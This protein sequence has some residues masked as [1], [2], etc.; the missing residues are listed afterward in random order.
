MFLG[1]V[2]M[3]SCACIK[4]G[5]YD[6][7]MNKNSFGGLLQF[8]SKE[9]QLVETVNE[10]GEDKKYYYYQSTVEKVKRVLDVIGYSIKST[11]ECFNEYFNYLT[12]E[13]GYEFTNFTLEE[14]HSSFTFDLWTEAV[15]KYARLLSINGYDYYDTAEKEKKECISIAESFVLDSLA[16]MDNSYFGVDYDYANPF[17]IFRVV[18]D[19]FDDTT[20][21]VLDY[22]DLYLGGWCEETPSNEEFEVSKT[23]I[24]TEGK[25]DVEVISGAMKLLYP[26]LCKCFSFMNFTEY[27]VNGST[28]FLTHYIKAFIA[29]GVQNQVIAI[30]DNDSAGKAELINL[31]SLQ[32]PSRFKILTLPDIEIANNYP[33]LGPSGNEVMNI[34]GL[35]CSIEF[36]LGAELL[37]DNDEFIPIQW[38]GYVEKTKTYQGEIMKKGEIQ[39]RFKKKLS[40]C[41][42]SKRYTKE[43][44]KEMNQLL[45]SIFSAFEN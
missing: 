15:K 18:L 17:S 10:D 36:F 8:F 24:L 43:N 44:W 9:D 13:D 31:S 25:F 45:I 6:F 39:N 32:I 42:E 33:T 21:V 40:S 16:F 35:A 7:L 3:G 4:I 22:T 14:I 34:N 28:N 5:N 41:L 23:I 26:E 29:A 1:D 38:N 11:Q 20:K 30:Y 27:K 37:K 12:Q 19:A 2:A